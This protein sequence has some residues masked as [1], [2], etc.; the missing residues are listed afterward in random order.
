M[1]NV[2]PEYLECSALRK[3]ESAVAAAQSDTRNLNRNIHPACEVNCQNQSHVSTLI[4]LLV[5]LAIHDKLKRNPF[6]VI[7]CCCL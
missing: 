3:N 5:Q 2:I 4:R 7:A 1:K 6:K